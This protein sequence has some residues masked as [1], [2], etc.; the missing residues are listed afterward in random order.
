MKNS[1]EKFLHWAIVIAIMVIIAVVTL[2]TLSIPVVLSVMFSWY[3]LFLYA[4]YLLVVLFIA[5]YATDNSGGGK[6]Q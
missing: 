1:Y 5:L 3:W 4:G 6:K 2:G